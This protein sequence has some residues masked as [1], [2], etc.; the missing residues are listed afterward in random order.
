MDGAAALEVAGNCHL[1]VTQILVLRAQRE[2]IAKR[3]GR[4][5]VAAVAAVDHRDLR[6]F[7]GEPRRAV[8]RMANN[9]DV[10]IIRNHP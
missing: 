9:D 10:G 5:L 2:Q 8:A 4:M 7:G 1:H 6:I 3:L